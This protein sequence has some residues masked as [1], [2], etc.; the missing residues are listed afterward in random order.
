MFDWLVEVVGDGGSIRLHEEVP[1]SAD[2]GI[3]EA[4]DDPLNDGLH[5]SAK[6]PQS[7]REIPRN[8]PNGR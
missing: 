1:L 2:E 5:V 7:C 6:A 8:G 3:V 4:A